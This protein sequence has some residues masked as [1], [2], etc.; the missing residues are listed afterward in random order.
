[1]EGNLVTL[2]IG[3][4]W[5]V[6]INSVSK[7]KSFDGNIDNRSAPIT[8]SGG[9]IMLRTDAVADHV[10]GKKKVNFPNKRKR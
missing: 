1:M 3:D 4:S 9:E 6:I 10:F 5:I 2:D 8:I 7:K